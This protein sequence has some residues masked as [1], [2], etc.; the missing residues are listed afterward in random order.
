MKKNLPNFKMYF[1]INKV[2]LKEK[3]YLRKIYG[4]KIVESF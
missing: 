4:K 3:K 2:K 1:T